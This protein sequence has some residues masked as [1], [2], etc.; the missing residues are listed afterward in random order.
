LQSHFNVLNQ[1]K[2]E[3]IFGRFV[4]LPITVVGD[5]MLDEYIH[6]KV[7][8][9]SPEAPVPVVDILQRTYCPGGAANVAVNLAAL[10]AKVHLCSVMGDD[11]NG[12]VLLE[13]LALSGLN[14]DLIMRSKTRKTTCKT[15]ILG[16]RHQMLR[17]DEEN[18][19][20]LSDEEE[21]GL[22]KMLT[23]SLEET[24]GILLQD[25][26]KGVLTPEI[27][28][29]T[30]SKASESNIPVTVDPKLR[31]F[32]L[33]RK[34]TL[35]KP[36][37]K[38]L[39]A[40]LGL[41]HMGKTTGELSEAH[42]RLVAMLNHRYTLITLSESGMFG[43]GPEE[44]LLSPAHVRNIADVSGAGDTVIAV[45]TLCLAAGAD[46]RTAVELANLAGGLVC[47]IPGAVPVDKDILFREAIQKL[48][49]P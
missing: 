42:K 18:T 39:K 10:G 14:T 17:L 49:R 25:Y 38:E 13:Q 1:G 7:D 46:F 16:N 12:N 4:G 11:D 33:Y 6:G 20:F 37:L 19:H 35:F 22:K 21:T 5:I 28:R 9:I 43:E 40:G 15:R 24:R 30:T 41:P 36:N 27:I 3:E 31:S 32:S 47:E 48:T 8:R 29:L 34:V 45:A 26:D 23:A 2:I 44:S